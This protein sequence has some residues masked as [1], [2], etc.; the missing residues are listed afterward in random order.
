MS[1]KGQTAAKTQ[2]L[3]PNNQNRFSSTVQRGSPYQKPDDKGVTRPIRKEK[4]PETKKE[5]INAI[6]KLQ[7][8][9][10]SKQKQI[11]ELEQQ[12]QQRDQEEEQSVENEHTEND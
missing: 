3:A 4:E 11:E 6:R 10:D 9:I 7:D 12:L 8:E 1:A 2:K 5:Y